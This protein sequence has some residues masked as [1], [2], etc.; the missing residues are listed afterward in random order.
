MFG[1]DLKSLA[2]AGLAGAIALGIG[3]AWG[4]IDGARLTDAAIEKALK[5]AER[6]TDDAISEL[7]DEADRAR[8]R[9][10]ICRDRGGVWSFTDNECR[11][12][13]AQP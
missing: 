10:R 11:K 5:E 8:L 3:F 2:A 9:L 1:L 13:E 7:A 12:A 6:N 4:R